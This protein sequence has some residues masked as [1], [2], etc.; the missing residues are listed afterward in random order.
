VQPLAGKPLVVRLRKSVIYGRKEEWNPTALHADYAPVGLYYQAAN[1][2]R[3]GV[4]PAVY[5]YCVERDLVFTLESYV[6]GRP[7]LLAEL[8]SSDALAIG[9]TLGEF[10]QALHACAAPLPGS[11]LLTWGVQGVCAALPDTWAELWQRRAAAVEQ[12]VATLSGATL[13]LARATLQRQAREAVT[14][15]QEE[16]AVLA[17]VNRDVTPENLLA[18]GA[19]WV[20]LVDPVPLQ[21]S[22][23]YYAA[24]F[25]HC[26]RL[27]LLALSQAPRYVRHRFHMHHT[28][29]AALAEGYEIGYAQGRQAV[30]RRL[31]MG[32]W[33]WALDFAAES[34]TLLQGGLTAAMQ[35]RRGD[36]ATVTRI[37]ARCLRA[38]TE[39]RW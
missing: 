10:F 16:P 32:E 7:L 9:V 3:P 12:Q 20:G 27:A 19:A 15:V 36:E 11:G 28:T 26:Y 4:C 2:C 30:Q 35:L 37:L 33:L 6:G 25:L 24:F 14:G 21:E 1:R 22:S 17:L 13:G 34:Y 8:S 5:H 29:L 39:L 31:R 38:L 18:Q 23:T